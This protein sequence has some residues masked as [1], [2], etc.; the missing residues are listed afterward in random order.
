MLHGI[1][2]PE[3]YRSDSEWKWNN[4]QGRYHDM[5][6]DLMDV[7]SGYGASRFVGLGKMCDLLQIPSKSFLT[8]PIYEHILDGE[9]ELVGE[10]CKLDCLDTL[11]VFLVWLVHRGDL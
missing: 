8:K 10:Y 11:L 9:Q 6:V 5:H 4:Y 2:A 3:L 7:L 1:A